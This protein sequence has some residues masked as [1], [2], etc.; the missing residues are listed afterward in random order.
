MSKPSEVLVID[1]GRII[2]GWVG[3]SIHRVDDFA[4][5]FHFTEKGERN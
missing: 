2:I 3:E 1:S 4:D 5:A